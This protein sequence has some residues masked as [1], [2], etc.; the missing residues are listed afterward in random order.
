MRKIIYFVSFLF[1]TF[2]VSCT[3]RAFTSIDVLRP[4]E[5]TF[6]PEVKNLVI[7]INSVSQ[8]ENAGHI[9]LKNGKEINKNVKSDSVALFCTASVRENLENKGFFNSVNL[10]QNNRN[11]SDNF[12]KVTPLSKNDVQQLCAMYNAEAVLSLDHIY[13]TDKTGTYYNVSKSYVATDVSVKTTW[14]VHYPTYDVTPQYI[15]FADSFSWESNNNKEHPTLYNTLVDAA[16]ITGANVADRLIPHWEKQDR[17][18][19]TSRN[20][21]MQ[22]AM[23]AVSYNKWNK[24]IEIWNEILKDDRKSKNLKF[25]AANNM[26]IAHE[27]IEDYETAIKYVNFAIKLYPSITITDNNLTFSIYKMMSYLEYLKLREEEIKL[28]NKQLGKNNQ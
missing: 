25:Q 6:N 22:Q 3:T 18:F 20:S 12:Y 19:Y 11:H 14:S 27:I 17:Y 1:I 4:A 24:A 26:A 15:Q 2:L 8:P 7:V 13:V 28:L 9:L 16:I 23:E 10:S 5:V 21:L